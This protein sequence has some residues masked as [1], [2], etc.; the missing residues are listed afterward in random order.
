M[1]YERTL[2]QINGFIKDKVVPGVSYSIIDGSNLISDTLGYQE[3]VPKKEV[4]V[5]GEQYDLASL[6]KVVGT[7][8][9]I[10]LLLSQGKLRLSDSVSKYLAE[11]E[12]PQVTIRHLLTHTSDLVGYIPRRD[13]LPKDDLL[14][15]ILH[16]GVGKNF[17]RLIHYQDYNFILLGLIAK[18]ITGKPI[19]TLVEQNILAPLELKQTTFHP[20]SP[21]NVVPTTYNELTHK[22]LR[23]IVH[24]PKAQTLGEDCGSAGLFSTLNDLVHFSKWILSQ[25]SYDL[26]SQK[27]L[28]A[29][30]VDQTPQKTGGRSL[31][32]ILRH[33]GDHN[34]I[35]HTGYTGTLI[36]LDKESQKGLVFLTNRIHPKE[37]NQKFLVYRSKLIR[38]FIKEANGI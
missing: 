33:V 21:E 17:G 16:L 31:G 10:L 35:L 9:E 22:L 8:N 30:W 11:W 19:Q 28:D 29:L 13:D 3:L 14:Y 36:V 26:I 12:Y 32:W 2:N 34:Y 15:A 38:T 25:V 20:Q 1:A 7:T 6:T 24:D 5:A 27:W 4:L 37:N 18:Q 23:G